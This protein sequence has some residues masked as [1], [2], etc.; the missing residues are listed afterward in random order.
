MQNRTRTTARRAAFVIP[1]LTLALVAS[2]AWAQ[3]TY[4]TRFD[5][6]RDTLFSTA[7]R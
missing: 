2:P 1:T 5:L 6:L 3:Q 4:V 7:R